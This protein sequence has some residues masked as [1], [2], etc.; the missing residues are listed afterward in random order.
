MP[1]AAT[2]PLDR[3]AQF[4]K[5]VGPKRAELLTRLG[6]RSAR[7]LLFHVPR[8]YE[9]ASTVLPIGSAEPGMDV[10]LIGEVVS[11]GV[12]PTRPGLRIFQAVI[13]DASGLIE[14]SWPGQPFLDRTIRRGDLLLVTGPV[15]KF[16]RR[17]IQPREF[18]ILGRVDED[19]D[20]RG[21]VL[22]IYPS[23]EGLS[24]RQLRGIIEANLDPLLDAVVPEEPF[25]PTQ[26]RALGLPPLRDAL[27]LMHRPASLADAE[28]GRR[29][30]AYEE[31]FFLQLLHARAHYRATLERAGTSFART[32]TLIG[33]LYHRLPFRLTGAQTRAL[34]EIFAD[35]TSPRRMNR[36][37]Q[38]DVGSGK[39]VVA[40]FAM[41][42]AAESG[43]Q[44]ALMAPTEILAEQHAR[45][46]R[47]LLADLPVRVVLLTGRQGA[48]ERREVAQAIAEGDAHIAVGTHALI[49]E[50][51][52][53]HRLGLA[54]VD[55]QHRFG[56][57]QRRALAE[58]GE[59][60]DVLVMSATPIPRSLALTL[61]GDLDLTVL[62]EL[63]PGR[64]PIRTTLRGPQS[65]SKI[66]DFVREQVAEG[67]QAYLVYPLVEESE[68]V[69][70]RA[71]TEEYERL[72]VEVF[73]EL[74]V[75]LVHGQMAGEEKDRTM[76]AF[77]AGELDILVST[78]VIEVGIDVANAT[79]MVIEHAERFG[80]SQLHQLRGRVG[81]GGGA[82]YCILISDGEGEAARLHTFVATEDG[83]EIARADLRL[84][85]MGDFF[86]AKQHGVP[87]FR[88]FDPEK[89]DDLL[90]RGREQA[91]DLV[92]S[93]PELE[94][95]AAFKAVLISRYGEREKLYEVG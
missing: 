88:H 45:T 38:G 55:E 93:D 81:R 16:H 27:E 43:Y 13:R 60:T 12:I 56:V 11:K 7:D 36:L 63:P 50:R 47:R 74:R 75:G 5:S 21:I 8:R 23:T 95:H 24:Q 15:R 46:L 3:P 42:L 80:L 39:T 72:R 86:G 82:S 70:L 20:P 18:I 52:R 41:L 2:S 76:R 34:R 40:L 19:G 53:F 65:R 32:D 59:R 79:V 29:R 91:R 48:A 28:R 83:F 71:A 85:G 90:L 30:L 25:P 31:L 26:L 84:R 94:A 9:D 37:V 1:Q 77:A 35:M 33:A 69:D 49:Q 58:L 4:L 66:Y 61:H 54:V 22:P 10:T 51:V 44:A 68:K 14:C 17:Q 64:Q 67:R 6:V 89:D 57:H 62:D 73:P 87:D 92:A 78:T